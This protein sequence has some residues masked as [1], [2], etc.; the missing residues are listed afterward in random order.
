LS[1]RNVR[2]KRHLSYY[3]KDIDLLTKHLRTEFSK[4][5]SSGFTLSHEEGEEELT[6][7]T[8]KRLTP[9]SARRHLEGLGL[10]QSLV[11]QAVK[12]IKGRSKNRT[13][14]P[15]HIHWD[16]WFRFLH[17]KFVGEKLKDVLFATPESRRK[18]KER[19]KQRGRSRDEIALTRG[20]VTRITKNL[21][22]VVLGLEVTMDAIDKRIDRWEKIPEHG[23]TSKTF[24][25]M[26]DIQDKNP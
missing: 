24:T 26:W 6:F 12:S 25:F 18:W 14:K 13:P 20:A 7:T 21:F 10:K 8:H 3:K 1:E 16:K 22:K 4:A 2:P 9:K 23:V 19:L 15:D 17:E 5:F 11:E